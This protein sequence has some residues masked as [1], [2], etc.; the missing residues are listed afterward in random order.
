VEFQ[1][2]NRGT[3]PSIQRPQCIFAPLEVVCL[4]FVN[5]AIFSC[6]ADRFSP[7]ER[8]RIMR[9]VLSKNTSPELHVR[10]T[11][12]ALGYRFRLH[13]E[14]LPGKPDLAFPA[15]KKVIF[16]N[17]CFWHLHK[18]C[19][20]AK[21]PASRQEFWADKLGRNAQRDRQQLRAIRSL[22]WEA[23]VIWECQTHDCT[24]LHQTLR[25]FLM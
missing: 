16:V 12:H 20:R 4:Q 8:S 11:A 1:N 2:D 10:R 14:R 5:W 19:S 13:Y 21:L 18:G 6:V 22:G 7:I 15:R 24:K 17:G 23:L 3:V 9:S 25:H